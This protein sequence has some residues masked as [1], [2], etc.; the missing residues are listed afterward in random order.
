MCMGWPCYLF[1]ENE[2]MCIKKKDRKVKLIASRLSAYFNALVYNAVYNAC[3]LIVVC[4][5]I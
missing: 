4:C 3:L 5:F 1:V 2:L